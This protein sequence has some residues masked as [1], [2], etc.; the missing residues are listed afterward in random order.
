MAQSP[1]PAAGTCA[2]GRIE[3]PPGGAHSSIQIALAKLIGRFGV[4]LHAAGPGSDQR[5]VLLDELAPRGMV[6]PIDEPIEERPTCRAAFL[7]THGGALVGTL[8]SPRSDDGCGVRVNS[9][10]TVYGDVSICPRTG[11]S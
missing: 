3:S 11:P 4:E 1:Q 5:T 8:R 2:T 7:G 10:R 6:S 9:P